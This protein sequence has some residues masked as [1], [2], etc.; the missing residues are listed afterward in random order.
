MRLYTLRLPKIVYFFNK[1]RVI[2][3]CFVLSLNMYPGINIAVF[4][5]SFKTEKTLELENPLND[6][7]VWG[8][9][10]YPLNDSEDHLLQ[11]CPFVINYKVRR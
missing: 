6:F 3:Q 4:I 8:F 2:V 1:K 7:L 9:S 10:S 11:S 5:F